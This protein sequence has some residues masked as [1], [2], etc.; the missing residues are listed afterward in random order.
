MSYSSLFTILLLVLLPS[1]STS[2]TFDIHTS[3]VSS[4][5]LIVDIHTSSANLVNT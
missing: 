3:K 4:T 5:N 1:L 2:L